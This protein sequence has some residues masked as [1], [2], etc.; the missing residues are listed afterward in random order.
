M[1]KVV[2]WEIMVKGYNIIL[3][4]NSTLKAN[5][6]LKVIIIKVIKGKGSSKILLSHFKVAVQFPTGFDPGA[7]L[8]TNEGKTST[9][10]V[11][12]MILKRM[13][14]IEENGKVMAQQYKNLEAQVGQMSQQQNTMEFQMEHYKA[15]KFRS[16]TSYQG[17]SIPNKHDEGEK[18]DGV[19]QEEE[20]ENLSDKYEEEEEEEIV[21]MQEDEEE[22][23]MMKNAKEEKRIPK[24]KR[25]K[26]ANEGNKKVE[27]DH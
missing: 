27:K 11:L 24:W 8:P 16:G 5:F 19:E 26:E 12:N 25:A 7:K 22:K 15:I 3:K 23:A 21:H 17:P 14:G 9:D 18:K 4:V 1:A 20:K 10:E 13:D 2:E 6:K